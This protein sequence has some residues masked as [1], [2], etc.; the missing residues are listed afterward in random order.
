[1]EEGM[2]VSYSGQSV[3]TMLVHS[4]YSASSASATWLDVPTDWFVNRVKVPDNLQGRGYGSQ[5][6]QRLI[7]E[8]RKRG[9][10]VLR[11]EPGGYGS[12]PDRLEKFYKKNGFEND[13]EFGGRALCLCFRSTG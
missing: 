2:H 1:M 6:L 8:L 7:E 5:V 10:R 13:T 12:D 11:V 3:T 9:V 4:G